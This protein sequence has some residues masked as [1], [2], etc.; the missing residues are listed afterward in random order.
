MINITMINHQYKVIFIHVPKTGGNSIKQAFNMTGHFHSPVSKLGDWGISP[1][2][3]TKYT[4]LAFVRNPWDRLVSCYEYFRSGGMQNKHDLHIK[5]NYINGH[6]TFESFV[7]KSPLLNGNVE[8]WERMHFEPQAYY[9]D[10]PVDYIGKF[11]NIENDFKEFRKRIN[12]PCVNLP[13]INKTPS[14]R[15]KYIE[16]Y[17]THTVDHVY[18]LYEKDIN[19]YNYE[20]KDDIA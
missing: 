15:K 20:Y 19:T 7:L 11:E 17:N 18:K 1:E 10:R 16:Y 6:D 9:I 5:N 8:W 2:T 14:D 4:K 13:H 12:A 3:Q